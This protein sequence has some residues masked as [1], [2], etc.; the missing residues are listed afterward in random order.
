MSITRSHLTPTVHNAATYSNYGC[1][2]DVCRKSESERR[3]RLKAKRITR[4]AIPP[5]LHGRYT[6]YNNWLCRCELCRQA[7]ADYRRQG[8]TR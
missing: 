7:W 1:R 5:E 6:T 4:T 2:C 3:A 8:R